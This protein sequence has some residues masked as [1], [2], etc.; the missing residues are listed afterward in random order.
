MEKGFAH[1]T[2]GT[3]YLR[4]STFPLAWGVHTKE[5]TTVEY[6]RDTRSTVLQFSIGRAGPVHMGSWTPCLG[7]N[8]DDTLDTAHS[9]SVSDGSA[10][11]RKTRAVR[12]LKMYD[13]LRIFHVEYSDE[14]IHR[15]LIFHARGNAVSKIHI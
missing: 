5:Y 6:R 2:V 8:T 3:K 4:A 14:N 12:A 13:F 11:P 15:M 7:V 9:L 1:E 10:A